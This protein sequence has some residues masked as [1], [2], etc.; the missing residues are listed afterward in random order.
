MDL[1]VSI[2]ILDLFFHSEAMPNERSERIAPVDR[3]A[4]GENAAMSDAQKR[5]ALLF[6][7]KA[8]CVQCMRSPAVP[9]NYS[10]I[11]KCTWREFHRSPRDFERTGRCSFPQCW[12]RIF[13]KRQSRFWSLRYHGREPGHLQVPNIPAAEFGYSTCFLSQWRVHQSLRSVA[14]SFGCD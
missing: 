3:F 6:F 13:R 14:S 5:G 9:T 12:R 8:S 11:S 4:R 2:K 7:G 1:H 10:A